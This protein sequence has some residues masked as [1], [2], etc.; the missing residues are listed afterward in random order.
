MAETGKARELA[1]ETAVEAACPAADVPRSVRIGRLV[2]IV[3]I[4]GLFAL[5]AF[6]GWFGL[7][8]LENIAMAHERWRIFLQEQ[9]LLSLLAFTGLYVLVGALCVPGGA[10]LTAAGGLAFGVVMGS[11]ATVVGAT[12]GAML[13]FLSARPACGEIM[14]RAKAGWVQTLREGFDRNALSYLLFLRLVPVFP[15]WF[16]NFAS[17]VLGVPVRTFA[18]GTF[19]GIMPA[20]VAF[21]S[22]GA[23]LG[24]V[25][26]A[27]KTSYQSCLAAGHGAACRFAIPK[28]ALF[29]KELALALVL[30]GLLALI[31]VIVERWRRTDGG[32][33]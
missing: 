23:G 8:T 20:T 22:A 31:P 30:L 15:F 25:I 29:T 9:L 27:S 18:V 32:T 19:F 3:L 10:L 12:A 14:L 28:S 33:R 1:A 26:S 17:A 24:S 4:G 6:K 7:L 16:V 13:L 21:A 11:I 5:A 2:P